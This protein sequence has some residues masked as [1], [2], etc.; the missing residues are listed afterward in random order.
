VDSALEFAH[1]LCLR[2]ADWACAHRARAASAGAL[3][4]A[5]AAILVNHVVLL[6]FPN[7]GD[8]YVYLYQAA[9]MAEGRLWNAAPRYPEFF[10]FNYIVQQSGRAYGSFP[11][12]WP[13][14]LAAALELNLPA[15]V[16]NPILGAVSV[17]LVARL[18]SRLYGPRIGAIAA[19][20]TAVTPFFLFNAASYFS[21]TFCG[22]LLLG[23]ACL[24]ARE[25]RTPPW[26][27]MAVGFL[28]GWAVLARYFTGVVVG[29]PIV[30]F[31]LRADPHSSRPR[32][33]AALGTL[34]LV[35]AGG[36]PWLLVLLAYN[37]A[38]SGNPW[39]LTTLPSTVSLW[40]RDG[41]VLR[42]A[43]ILSTHLGRWALWTPPLLVAVYL[44]Y[45]RRAPR[46]LRRGALH[47]LPIIVAGALYFYVE[48][49]GNQ[50]GPRFHYEVLPF[51][52]LFVTANLFGD[53]WPALARQER[54]A[55]AALAGSVALLPVLFVLHAMREH[56]VIRERTDPY[57]TVAE[58]RLR[59]ALVL[60]GGRIGTERSMDARDLTRNGLARTGSVL[61]ALDLGQ[62]RSCFLSRQY[63][64]RTPYVYTWDAARDDGELRPLVCSR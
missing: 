57:T 29:V 20:L 31:L 40:F 13:L 34:M 60:I 63:P 54:H 52:V 48:R 11:V 58:A 14:L 5:A 22:T 64:G 47:W 49:G 35:A 3:A 50:Y 43:D 18:G 26:A 59:N 25:N 10:E 6:Q 24:A 56:E 12:G 30:L 9:T 17:L 32:L 7:S 8:E 44:V 19:A 36:A 15:W 62:E 55:F 27:P 53:P 45:L 38:M 23:A 42:G 33:Q 21:H 28:V 41:F 37:E 16:V 4:V 1:T 46:E 51:L 61:Y 39:T 2:A